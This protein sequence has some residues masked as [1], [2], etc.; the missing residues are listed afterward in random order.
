MRETSRARTPCDNVKRL[1]A[2]L[3]DDI[4]KWLKKPTANAKLGN[5]D[6]TTTAEP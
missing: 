1:N 6:E 4:L 3:S 5:A 2:E